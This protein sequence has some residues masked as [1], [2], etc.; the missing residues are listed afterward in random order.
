MHL[1]RG[2][3]SSQA[4]AGTPSPACGGGLG[5]GCRRISVGDKAPISEPQIPAT[6]AAIAF[7][8]VAAEA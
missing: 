7:S 5:W 1:V 6:Y 2:T 3:N 8:A 4:K